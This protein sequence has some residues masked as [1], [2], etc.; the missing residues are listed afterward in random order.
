MWTERQM[1]Q[2]IT[3][4]D[5]PFTKICVGDEEVLVMPKD[6]N[7]E[8]ARVLFDYWKEPCDEFIVV[9]KMKGKANE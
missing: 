3:P 1:I 2:R 9:F 7:W 8:I 5:S 6:G 4:S